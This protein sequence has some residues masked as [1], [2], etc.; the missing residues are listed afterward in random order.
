MFDYR[1]PMLWAFNFTHD[2]A[3]SDAEITAAIDQVIDDVRQHPISQEELDRARTKLRSQLY[4]GI[5]TPGHLGLVDLLAS[6]ALFDD[7]PGAVNRIEDCFA[8]VTAADLQH[9][10]CFFIVTE[11]S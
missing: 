5:D 6:Y 1:G 4:A 11:N 9:A 3:R 10:D 8:R 2:P 7:D